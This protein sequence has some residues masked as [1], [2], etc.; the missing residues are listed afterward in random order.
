[1]HACFDD[2]DDPAQGEEELVVLRATT[3][4]GHVWDD[5][6][7]DLLFELLTDVEE[8]TEQFVVVERPADASGQ[9]YAQVIL[10]GGGD[11]LLERRDGSADLHFA[12]SLPDKQ[13]AHQALTAWAFEL[14]GWESEASWRAINV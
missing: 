14:P 8:G 10:G 13:A 2:A 1:M 9:T 3:E 12:A 5:P 7:E 6:S 11:W 4:Q